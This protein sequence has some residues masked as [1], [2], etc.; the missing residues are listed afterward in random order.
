MYTCSILCK[1]SYFNT[2]IQLAEHKKMLCHRSTVCFAAFFDCAAVTPASLRQVSHIRRTVLAF[3]VRYFHLPYGTSI[4]RTVL[5]FTVRYFH[6]PYGTSIRRTVLP[7]T[8]RYFHSPF[9]TSDY[10]TVLPFAVRYFRLPYGTSICR[11]ADALWFALRFN[12][13]RTTSGRF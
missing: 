5:A 11:T 7:F 8:V 1:W 10:R 2:K 3:T 4:R 13:N 12:L 9:G 6:L